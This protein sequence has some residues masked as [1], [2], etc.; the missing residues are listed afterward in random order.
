[1][2]R[3]VWFRPNGTTQLQVPGMKEYT[4]D[5]P[6]VMG[7]QPLD[8]TVVYVWGDRMVNLMVLDHNGNQFIATSVTLV[9]PGEEPPAVGIYAQWMPYQV[10]TAKKA[11]PAADSHASAVLYPAIREAMELLEGLP[12]DFSP[13]VNRAFNVLHD[14]FWS[15]VPSPVGAA[16]KRTNLG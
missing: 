8:A 7:D 2:G 15:E 14:A 16:L 12:E 3:K 4:L 9:Q 13:T 11:E 6:M 1:M 10:A 5:F